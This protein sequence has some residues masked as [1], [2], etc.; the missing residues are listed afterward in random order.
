MLYT[1]GEENF[2]LELTAPIQFA[3]QANFYNVDAFNMIGAGSRKKNAAKSEYQSR[4]SWYDV[5]HVSELR[6]R[7]RTNKKTS[8]RICRVALYTAK[9]SC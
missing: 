1:S 9:H 3:H 7:M 5:V 2:P 6:P 4:K 8:D